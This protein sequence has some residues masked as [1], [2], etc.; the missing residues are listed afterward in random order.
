MHD[1]ISVL[2]PELLVLVDIL[3]GGSICLGMLLCWHCH[4]LL[5]QES[6][7]AG[8][9]VSLVKR[10]SAVCMSGPMSCLPLKVDEKPNGLY[11]GLRQTAPAHLATQ[12]ETRLAFIHSFIH[13][14]CD[15]GVRRVRLQIW[16]QRGEQPGGRLP[17]GD[18]CRLPAGSLRALLLSGAQP[19][20]FNIR[21]VDCCSDNGLLKASLPW[22]G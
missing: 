6:Q 16:Y 13:T 18:T 9:Q 2:H 19:P 14:W 7:I 8:H 10:D 4:Q 17:E 22:S 15:T 20:T 12:L 21:A 11:R 3:L 1:I 5:R